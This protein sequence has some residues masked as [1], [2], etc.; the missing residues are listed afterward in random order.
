MRTLTNFGLSFVAAAVLAGCG[1]SGGPSAS[2]AD[3]GGSPVLPTATTGNTIVEQTTVAAQADDS[4]NS[5]VRLIK[6]RVQRLIK[7]RV[8]N[9]KQIHL[10]TSLLRSIHNRRLNQHQKTPLLMVLSHKL[11]KAAVRYRQVFVM[12]PQQP[13]SVS[14]TTFQTVPVLCSLVPTFLFQPVV[15]VG[16][17]LLSEPI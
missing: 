14:R 7:V 2:V 6:V 4:V 10:R 3:A 1:G 8:Q 16:I 9:R 13:Q 12:Q 11:M 17:L 5:E 15:L